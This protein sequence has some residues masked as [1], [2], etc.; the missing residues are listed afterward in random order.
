MNLEIEG[1]QEL[2]KKLGQLAKISEATMKEEIAD[3]AMDLASKA[4]NSAP[5]DKGDLRRELSAPKKDGDGWKVGASLPYTRYQHERTDL[6]HP[7]GGGPKFLEKPFRENSPKY[8][9]EIGRIIEG[10]LR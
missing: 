4:S 6:V 10:K 3:I 1:L 7:R 9:K 5:V 8:L 2:N